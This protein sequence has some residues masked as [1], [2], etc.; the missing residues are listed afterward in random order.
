[1]P[2]EWKNP[3]EFSIATI[4]EILAAFNLLYYM[5]CILSIPLGSYFLMNSINRLMKKDLK[6][7]NKMAKDGKSESDIFES[8]SRFI[9]SHAEIKQLSYLKI[10]CKQSDYSK[11]KSPF[12]E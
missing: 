6:S 2:F 1:M 12:I 3:I 7:I 5:S 10:I 8:F 4:L 9:R 11:K